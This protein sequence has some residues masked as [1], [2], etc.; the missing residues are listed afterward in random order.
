M[1]YGYDSETKYWDDSKVGKLVERLQKLIVNYKPEEDYEN[2]I[3]YVEVDGLYDGVR[4]RRITH[5]SEADRKDLVSKAD[6]I[7]LEVMKQ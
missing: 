5:L 7:Y 1:N 2:Y 3:P 4:L 6:K